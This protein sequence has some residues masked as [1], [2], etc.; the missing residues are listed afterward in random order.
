VLLQAHLCHPR[1]AA[2]DNGS[3]VAVML[4]VA[5]RFVQTPGVLFAAVGA[6]ERVVT[7]S[8]YHLGSLRLRSSLTRAD[9]RSLRLVLSLDMVGYGTSLFVR[10]LERSPNRSARAALQAARRVGV[11]AVYHQDT[12]QSDHAEFT[13]GG[14]PAA[15]IE[16]WWD[17]CWHRAC[18][19]P[20]RLV[21][22]K[23]AA[24]E[25]LAAAAVTAAVR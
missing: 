16:W 25:R 14:I 11:R 3:G 6:E 9:R 18:D 8:R 24:V 2:N 21:P 1:P 19:R 23:L 5:R 7:G 12:G 13:R 15:W 20:D 22:K 4:E 10:G 17:P